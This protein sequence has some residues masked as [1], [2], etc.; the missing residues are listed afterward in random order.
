[1]SQ[2]FRGTGHLAGDPEARVTKNSNVTTV[3]VAF[4]TRWGKGDKDKR[5]DF[6][7]VTA[8]G[9][10]GDRLAL[11]AKGDR[12]HID[13][14]V[15]VNKYEDKDGNTKYST[16]INANSVELINNEPDGLDCQQDF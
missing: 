2:S 12:V 1:M 9:I 4:E 7:R 14:T 6:L 5:T 3:N 15:Q 10:M 8:W 13:G 11:A 16:N